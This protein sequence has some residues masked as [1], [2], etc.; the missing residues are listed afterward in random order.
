M[1]SQ[2]RY[3]TLA[4]YLWI[5]CLIWLRYCVWSLHDYTNKKKP[6]TTTTVTPQ[7][8]SKKSLVPFFGQ[9]LSF[10]GSYFYFKWKITFSSLHN[11]CMPFNKVVW[12]FPCEWVNLNL[13]MFVRF[14]TKWFFVHITRRQLLDW[15]DLFCYFMKERKNW[16][17]IE[18]QA[19]Y[20]IG[21]LIRHTRKPEVLVV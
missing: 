11:S 2:L 14:V 13:T 5:L 4:Y 20:I 15:V 8:K 10:S 9:H 3:L 17:N 19:K 18:Y 12:P 1:V 21:S 16:P 7:K 6:L